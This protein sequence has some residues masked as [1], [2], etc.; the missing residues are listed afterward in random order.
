MMNY[1]PQIVAGI[2]GL[3]LGLLLGAST[4]GLIGFVIL[5]VLAGFA[6]QT[7]K[8][9]SEKVYWFAVLAVLLM[10]VLSYFGLNISGFIF[11]AP[12]IFALTY[13]S[14]RLARRFNKQ[15]A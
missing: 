15:S 9:G 1:L 2:I 13:F 8:P 11:V 12:V 10:I 14:A 4:M 6:A 3:G 5:G 7:Q